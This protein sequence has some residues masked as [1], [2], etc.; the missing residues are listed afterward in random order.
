MTVAGLARRAGVTSDSI[1]YYERVGL[2]PQ[3]PRSGSGYR[4]YGED[5]VDRLRFIQGAQRLGLR[6]RE[7][8][9][10]LQIRDTGQCPCGDAAVLLRDRMEELDN[11]MKRL[12]ALRVELS[13]MVDQLP[14]NECP[15][16]EPGVWK[17]VVITGG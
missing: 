9:E 12:E 8:S 4:R 15:N 13:A 16:P 3:P 1:R 5:A 17:P 11:E 7:I 14:S 6:L 2:L 10:L